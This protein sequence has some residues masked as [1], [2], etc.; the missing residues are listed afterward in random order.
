MIPKRVSIAKRVNAQLSAKK[1]L[2]QALEK[3]RQKTGNPKLKNIDFLYNLIEKAGL[4]SQKKDVNFS[5]K[6]RCTIRTSQARRLIDARSRDRTAFWG[7]SFNPTLATLNKYFK[8]DLVTFIKGLKKGKVKVVSIGCGGGR[9]ESEL[10]KALGERVELHATGVKLLTQWMDHSNY[11]SINWHVTHANILTRTF[12]PESID[13]VYSRLGLHHAKESY[14]Q[15][16]HRAFSELEKIL[17]KDGKALIDMEGK[18][19]IGDLPKNLRILR[20]EELQEKDHHKNGKV[21]DH[22]VLLLEKTS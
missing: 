8:T 10:K 13:F 4:N 7:T 18:F 17:K 2:Q 21:Y 20:N 14:T 3:T 1:A 22:R 6:V 19:N 5:E 11:R 16:N 12:K 9:A 15:R